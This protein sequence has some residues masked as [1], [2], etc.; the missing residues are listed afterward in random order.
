MTNLAKTEKTFVLSL[1]GS[2]IVPEKVDTDFLGRFIALIKARVASGE[3]FIIVCGGGGVNRQYNQAAQEIRAL[4]NEELD[5][6][7]IH[8]TR[9]NAQFIRLLFGALA[10]EDIIINPYEKVTTDK[11]VLV[12][13]GYEPGWSSDYD[14]VYLAKTY[15]IPRLANLSNIDYAYD[16]DPNEFSDARKIEATSWAEFRKIVGDEWVPRMSKP[17][18]PIASREAEKLGLEVAILN[19]RN[20][21]NLE[22]YLDGAAFQGTVI[23]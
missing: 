16:K 19:G 7:G 8:T 11:P 9:L 4:T 14:A 13:A 6:L 12:G 3:R 15:D 5:W 21:E 2:L 1:G 18:D 23:R 17:F 22:K 10:Y 20:L